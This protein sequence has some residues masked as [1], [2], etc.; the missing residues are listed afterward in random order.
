MVFNNDNNFN[1]NGS[2]FEHT[3]I[4]NYPNMP[5]TDYNLPQNT[6]NIK[7]SN[8]ASKLFKAIS[9]KIKE[10]DS[11]KE[12]KDLQKKAEELFKGN[13]DIIQLL[14]SFGCFFKIEEN[15]IELSCE[16]FNLSGKIITNENNEMEFDEDA[17]QILRYIS[18]IIVS[19]NNMEDSLDYM[20]Q[21]GFYPVGELEKHKAIIEGKECEVLVGTLKNDKGETKQVYYYNGKEVFLSDNNQ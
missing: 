10:F 11:Q 1:P 15:Y 6:G 5:N 4:T 14:H 21:N 18:Q 8:F 12:I 2:I 19:S 3:D 16:K 13:E 7:G 9:E 20:E 17:E